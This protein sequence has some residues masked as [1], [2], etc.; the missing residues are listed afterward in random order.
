MTGHIF[1]SRCRYIQPEKNMR[2]KL[3][4]YCYADGEDWHS[5]DPATHHHAYWGEMLFDV[6]NVEGV[7]DDD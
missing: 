4:F 1:L 5:H 3:N 2:A 7:E 6:E